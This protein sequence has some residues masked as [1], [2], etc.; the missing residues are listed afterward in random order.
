M[1]PTADILLEFVTTIKDKTLVTIQ[2]KKPFSVAIEGEAL[3]I[4]T[5]TGKSRKTDYTEL[6]NFLTQ[7]NEKGSFQPGHY[8]DITFNASYIL[9]LIKLW[10][11]TNR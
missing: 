1:Y 6:Q 5:S 3:K 10:Q 4:T 2:R 9:A 7:L 8:A 11:D